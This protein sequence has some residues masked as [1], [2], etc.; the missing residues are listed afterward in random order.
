MAG[1][2]HV[3]V[4]AGKLQTLAIEG[5]VA[6]TATA[7]R[8]PISLDLDGQRANGSGSITF[9][10]PLTVATSVQLDSFDLDAYLPRPREPSVVVPPTAAAAPSARRLRPLPTRP[11]RCGAQGQGRQAR[12]P[13]PAIVKRHRRGSGRPGQ[14]PEGER[15]ES[16]RPAGRE[17]RLQGAGCG[18]RDGT[19][20]RPHVQCHDAGYRQA[21]G[22]C[23]PAEI[24]E[25]QAR[26]LDGGGSVAGT[27]EALTLR[28]ATVTA[29]GAS[30]RATVRWCW[31]TISPSTSPAS[32]AGAGCERLVSVATGK[33]QT[34]LGGLAAEG[35]FKGNDQRASFEAA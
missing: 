18:L 13:R 19:A 32:T 23:R 30:A 24:P 20:L 12:L 35:A 3:G 29:A 15:P 9:G 7:C 34:G 8:F 27:M 2:R 28:D 21:A 1:D 10:V 26:R 31:A 6:S 16:R 17:V 25:R 22:L 33:P 11:C 14:S 5:K 4:P